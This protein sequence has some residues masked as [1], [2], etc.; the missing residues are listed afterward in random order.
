MDLFLNNLQFALTITTPIFIILALGIVLKQVNILTDS[1]IDSGSKLVFM[2]ALPALLFIS[3]VQTPDQQH[4]NTDLVLYGVIA[5]LI[6][7]LL[8]EVAMHYWI[9]PPEDRESLCRALS[10][11]IWVSLG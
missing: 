9:T 7:Y 4:Q 1:F 11:L 5:T 2:V 3:I 6:V 10:V 8:L